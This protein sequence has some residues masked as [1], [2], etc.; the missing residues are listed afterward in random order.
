M[1]VEESAKENVIPI[2]RVRNKR[3]K[4][5]KGKNEGISTAMMTGRPRR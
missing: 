3:I 2:G 4:R 5:K 1:Q